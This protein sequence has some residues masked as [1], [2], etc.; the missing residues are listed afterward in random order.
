MH[1]LTIIG[2]R[3]QFIKASVVSLALSQIDGVRESL[4]HT[5]QHFD[6]NMSDIFFKE[7]GIP[8]PAVRLDIHGGS[9]GDMTGRMLAELEAVMMECKPDRV[10]VYGDTNSTLAGALAAAKLQIPVAHVEA[11]LRSFDRAMPEEINRIL[12]DQISDILFCPTDTAIRNLHNEGIGVSGRRDVQVLQVGDVMEDSTRLFVKAARKPKGLDLPDTYIACTFH[13]AE[14]TDDAERLSSLV[15]ALND[16]HLEHHV[17][18]PLHP[19]TRQAIKRLGLTLEA[20]A[21]MPL[22]YLEMLWLVS[23]ASLV[24]TDSGGLQKEAFFLQKPCIT[25]RNSTEWVETTDAGVNVLVDADRGR[26]LTEARERI[27]MVIDPKACDFG[28]GEASGRIAR[29]LRDEGR[30]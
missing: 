13:R 10:L 15:G 7:L 22:G 14:N 4:V 20:Q 6:A 27:G 28:G 5:G 24:V 21:I 29:I 16:L 8:E 12:T 17:V 11:G 2:A 9:H 1:L 3:P 26:L 25:A 30:S 18:I 19:R 23:N